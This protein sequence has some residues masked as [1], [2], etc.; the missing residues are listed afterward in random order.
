[1]QVV[2]KNIQVFILSWDSKSTN[3]TSFAD[4]DTLNVFFGF[5]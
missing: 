2:N 4:V 3:T 1:M 5:P